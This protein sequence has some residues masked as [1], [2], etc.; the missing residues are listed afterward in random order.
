MRI[1]SWNVNG[2]SANVRR[3]TFHKAMKFLEADIICCQ[4]TKTKC[5]VKMD[6]YYQYWN[7]ASCGG[8]S[9]KGRKGGYS[10]T[11][12]LSRLQPLSV[13]F[14]FGN[15]DYDTEGRAI[16]LEFDSFF[17]VD[18]Y[19]PN[20]Q[21]GPARMDYR[22]K[23]DAALQS[24]LQQLSKPV[25]ICGDFNVARDRIDVYP[26]NLKNNED[27]AGFTSIERENMELLLS[28]G[29]VDVF[30]HFYPDMRGCY[31][32]WS[33]RQESHR[34]KNKGWRLDYFLVSE[35]LIPSV[36]RIEHHTKILG[37]D[38][39][40]I[41]LDIKPP[42]Q[43]ETT[44]DEE[45]GRLW[46]E[47]DWDE[48][49]AY[50]FDLQR[51]LALAACRQ[52]WE[53]VKQ[54]QKDIV[55]SFAAKAM[56]VRHV[57]DMDSQPGIDGV[58]WVT[59][60]EKY[61]AASSLTSRDYKALP[62]KRIIFRD[63]K[64]NKT[65]PLNVPASYDKAM[66][67]LYSYSLDPV[68]ESL[69]DRKSFGFRKGRSYYDAHCY[70][71]KAFSGPDAPEWAVCADV[72][73]FYDDLAQPWLMK[74]IP[75]DKKV[76]HEFLVAGSV[77]GG[78]LFPAEKGISQS[79]STSTI[80][81]NMA[82]DGLQVYLQDRLFPDGDIDYRNCDLV[83]YADDMVIAT[84]SKASAHEI[85]SLLDDFLD[86][87]GLHLNEAKTKIVNLH[88]GFEFL[89]RWY[90]LDNTGELTC[91]PSGRA[92]GDFESRLST[93]I[94][95][96]NGSQA[97]LIKKVNRML[98]GFGNYH[99]VTEADEAFRHI[100]SV[101]DGLLVK[102]MRMLHPTRQWGHIRRKYWRRDE[103][104]YHIFSLEKNPSIHVERLSYMNLVEHTPV[105]TSFN[106]Y[107]DREYYLM[108]QQRRD[109][110][111]V[112]SDV[113]RSVWNRQ[114]GH[115]FYCG[116]EMRLDQSISLVEII[117][118]EGHRS[119]NLAYVHTHCRDDAY[120]VV[121]DV[122][123]DVDTIDLERLLEGVTE[124]EPAK[125][126]YRDLE[127]F[128]RLARKS[129][130]TLTFKQIEEI[131]GEELP[132][133]AFFFK[134]FW[135]DLIP[136]MPDTLRLDEN[137]CIRTVVIPEVDF[138]IAKSWMNQGYEIQ[139]LYLD[140]ERVVFRRTEENVSGLVI[141]DELIRQKIPDKA[142]YAANQFFQD[143]IEKYGLKMKK[144]RIP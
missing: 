138:P 51:Q 56:A 67:A 5:A 24:Y 54:Y 109:A 81:G 96:F 7:Q 46:R 48:M 101:V 65:R 6:G 89:S 9:D 11:L 16:T 118:G 104:G 39:C 12:V 130:F 59:D 41:S 112:N 28:M 107:L 31:T 103:N 73:E 124:P 72:A 29:Y 23:W 117:V 92:I 14:G 84:R 8:Y 79:A 45:A 27:T 35:E 141:P 121:V 85:L 113:K 74:H 108:L 53:M 95:N 19:V 126:P 69:G 128:F 3:G 116:K 97:T 49:E 110:Q 144:G 131:I 66:Q 114:D 139:S 36:Q 102:K 55:R 18:V 90:R 37:S 64:H 98:A 133:E 20:S 10:G 43:S 78:E 93:L 91:V 62:Y 22:A 42:E 38:H 119:N 58:K 132:W 142:V 34:P 17:V 44:S 1:V 88:E 106:P 120:N 99:R 100:D 60:S 143:L 127:E 83:R 111:K 76:L 136:G 13:K 25:V 57:V 80:I 115:C 140:R 63:I 26:E 50:V 71:M 94:L 75:M 129:P 86:E 21:D 61:R 105:R 125:S 134:S 30:R 33:T 32:W 47:I 122:S 77:Y 135:Y 68:A 123:A 52:D 15:T 87:R 4:E 70:I 40:P 137:E 2:L 82:L